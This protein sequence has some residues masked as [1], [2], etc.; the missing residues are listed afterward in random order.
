MY[1][2]KGLGVIVVHDSVFVLRDRLVHGGAQQDAKE[3]HGRESQQEGGQCQTLKTNPIS[4]R[5]GAIEGQGV[6]ELRTGSARVN[7]ADVSKMRGEAF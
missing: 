6:R 7:Q 1:R 2:P 5:E 3:Q 4:R